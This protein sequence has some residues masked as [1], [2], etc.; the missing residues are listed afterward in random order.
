LGRIL[1]CK[2]RSKPAN[3]ET[4]DEH[5]NS[6]KQQQKDEPEEGDIETGVQAV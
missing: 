6:V 2:K 1:C 3:T 5:N 4:A